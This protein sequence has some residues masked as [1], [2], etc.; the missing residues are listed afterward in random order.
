MT[1]K[2][3]LDTHGRSPYSAEGAWWEPSGLHE[4]IEGLLARDPLK[5]LG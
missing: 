3:T 2:L 4:L 1:G 5:R